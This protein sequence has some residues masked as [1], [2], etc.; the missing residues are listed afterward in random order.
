LKQFTYI[1]IDMKI[2]SLILLAAITMATAC[3]SGTDKGTENSAASAE[4][5]NS[6]C[7]TAVQGADSAFMKLNSAATG[8]ITGD[9]EIIY[10]GKPGHK[11]TLSGEFKGDTLYADYSFNTGGTKTNYKNPMAI[12]RDGDRMIL[13]VGEIESYLGKSY[14]KKGVPINYEIAKFKF[15][16]TACDT[17]AVP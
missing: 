14:F 17:P 4:P 15:D 9:L 16:K 2:Q 8:K 6:E 13:G 3:T 10:A 11:G 1:Q 7:Y 12:L 5:L